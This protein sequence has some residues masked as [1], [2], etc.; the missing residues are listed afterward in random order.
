MLNQCCA[1]VYDAGT[2]LVQH[3]SN[4][5]LLVGP[6]SWDAHSMLAHRLMSQNIL[7]AGQCAS[8]GQVPCCNQHPS[9]IHQCK[10]AGGGGGGFRW[11]SGTALWTSLVAPMSLLT[12]DVLWHSLIGQ[13]R[14]QYPHVYNNFLFQKVF[15]TPPTRKYLSA[16]LFKYGHYA[17]NYPSQSCDMSCT[18]AYIYHISHWVMHSRSFINVIWL[19]SVYF[20]R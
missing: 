17:K 20:S 10:H 8:C 13:C 2:T 1:S 4:G 5:R 11:E 14:N 12:S 7:L 15:N 19:L 18:P 9:L 16:C 6:Q 3:W